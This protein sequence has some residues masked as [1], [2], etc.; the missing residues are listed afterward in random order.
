[1]IPTTFI[2]KPIPPGTQLQLS[3]SVQPGKLAQVVFHTSCN[4]TPQGMLG[5][6]IREDWKGKLGEPQVPWEWTF[7]EPSY[8]LNPGDLVMVVGTSTL[9]REVPNDPEPRT[10]PLA[11]VQRLSDP[12]GKLA[13]C[14]SWWLEVPFLLNS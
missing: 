2:D 7:P 1:M 14:V 9:I 12:Q 6:R 10:F 11:C 8:M 5:V 3:H 13:W 4:H